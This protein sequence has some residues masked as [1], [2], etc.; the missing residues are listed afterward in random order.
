[1]IAC[2]CMT[3]RRPFE[4]DTLASLAMK[5]SL[6]RSARPSSLGPVPRGF[7]A[8][9]ARCTELDPA[10]RFASALELPAALREVVDAGD[11]VTTEPA[12]A[13]P[14]TVQQE[15]PASV[16]GVASHAVAKDAPGRRRPWGL[17]AALLAG[18]AALGAVA[19]WKGAPSTARVENQ[20]AV[21]SV[22]PSPAPHPRL[23]RADAGAASAGR[24]APVPLEASTP[25]PARAISG[26]EA[27]PQPRPSSSSPARIRAALAREAG[28]RTKPAASHDVRS[29]L[30]AKAL[31]AKAVPTQALPAK[32]APPSDPRPADPYDLP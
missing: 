2:E 31:P 5:I 17:G 26:S 30:P 6:S 22:L 19:L 11:L 21:A 23:E 20:R 28:R 1:V 29:A 25:L 3:G 32:A 12:E 7:D 24:V 10:R 27:L 13:P 16:A 15:R 14:A 4:G 18:A 8:W 9:F